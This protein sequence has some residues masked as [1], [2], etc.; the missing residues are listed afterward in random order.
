LACS[1][2]GSDS[3]AREP[4]RVGPDQRQQPGLERAL[5]QLDVH[6]ELV[7]ADHVEQ[8]LQGR[9]LGVEQQLVAGVEDPQV[10]LHLA[11]V[12]QERGVGAGA[13]DQRL[14]VVGDLP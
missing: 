3:G 2:S 14:D 5:V 4:A 1:A 12:G 11:L 7:A 6:P 8:P 10:A 9:A 13:G